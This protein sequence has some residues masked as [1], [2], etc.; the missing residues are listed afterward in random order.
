MQPLMTLFD[1]S[2]LYLI[3]RRFTEFRLIE[4]EVIEE[5]NSSSSPS[6]K[7][8]ALLYDMETCYATKSY[9]ACI[10]IAATAIEAS[11]ATF[12]GNKSEGL[13]KDLKK[14]KY[15]AEADWLRLLRN[16]IVH[17]PNSNVVELRITQERE[18]ELDEKCK[19]A[20]RLVHTIYLNPV[21]SDS[22]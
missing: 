15:A 9:F 22:V 1:E 18:K 19:A 20:F 10:L 4:L 3:N 21:K 6:W 14:S 7:S 17:K 5:C 12:Y 8:F 16:S 11:L 2:S 13:Y